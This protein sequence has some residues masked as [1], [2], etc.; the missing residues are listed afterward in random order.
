MYNQVSLSFFSPV[1]VH[2]AIF[3][4]YKSYYVLQH[5]TAKRHVYNHLRIILKKGLLL[6]KKL[7]KIT[8]HVDCVQQF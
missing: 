3:K 2:S 8:I 6:A 4:Q 1:S 7:N 5:F